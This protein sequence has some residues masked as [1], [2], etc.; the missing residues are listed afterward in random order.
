MEKKL[1]TETE[2]KRISKL[3]ETEMLKE[4]QSWK[5]SQWAAYLSKGVTFDDDEL[6]R[7][8]EDEIIEK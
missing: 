1:I 5:P 2:V 6:D 3:N 4:F 8:I 7:Y